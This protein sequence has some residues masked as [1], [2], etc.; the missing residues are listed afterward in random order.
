MKNY[1]VIVV[2]LMLGSYIVILGLSLWH[3][4][5]FSPMTTFQNLFIINN[6]VKLPPQEYYT[7]DPVITVTSVLRHAGRSIY[8]NRPDLETAATPMIFPHKESINGIVSQEVI[9]AEVHDVNY[10][11]P[12]RSGK[13]T[14]LVMIRS[15]LRK[16]VHERLL[17][18]E[19]FSCPETDLDHMGL[20]K[21]VKV[22]IYI[23][24]GY[25]HSLPTRDKF[26]SKNPNPEIGIDFMKPAAD[27]LIRG[28]YQAFR[29]VNNDIF[30]KLSNE[31][32]SNAM[33]R[34]PMNPKEDVCYMLAN[35]IREGRHFA[36]LSIQIHYGRGNE[37]TFK[38]A[39]HVDAENSL[40]HLAVTLRGNRTLHSRRRKT[41]FG[42]PDEVKEAQKAGDVYLSSSALM[43]HAPKFSDTDYDTRVIAIHARILYTSTEVNAFR[44]VRTDE[45]WE[46]L[47]TILA[48]NLAVAKII[49]PTLEDIEQ[50]KTK[51]S[52]NN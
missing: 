13:R 44:A 49:I 14:P 8:D 42:D 16:D 48:E 25:F 5:T 34:R 35:W 30:E 43:M 33:M 2:I 52:I 19:M 3:L 45:S 9:L 6:I 1:K 46:S 12:L 23:F 37:P 15:S 4:E 7:K 24:E 31:L 47:T 41:P 51:L 32:A 50:M 36:D 39:W 10:G 27:V 22:P 26:F 29:D 21:R 18:V 28:F 40:L 17:T 11:S 20:D 38:R